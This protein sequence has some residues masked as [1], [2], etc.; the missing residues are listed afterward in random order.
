MH[1]RIDRLVKKLSKEQRD[2]LEEM[3]PRRWYYTIED[4]DFMKELEKLG[5]VQ[6]AENPFR[7]NFLSWRKV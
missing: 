5:F 3:Q 2:L 6:S 1:N 4:T 7:P